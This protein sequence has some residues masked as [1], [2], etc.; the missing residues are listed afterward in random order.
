VEASPHPSHFEVLVPALEPLAPVVMPWLSA[1]L[2]FDI[3]PVFDF[4][5]DFFSVGLVI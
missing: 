4:G 3:E 5:T 2:S 1:G